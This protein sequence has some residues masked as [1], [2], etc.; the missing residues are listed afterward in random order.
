M[1]DRSGWTVVGWF[2]S[3]MYMYRCSLGLGGQKSEAQQTRYK[4]IT[5]A[6]GQ[7]PVKILAIPIQVDGNQHFMASLSYKEERT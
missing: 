5:V 7:S 1:A 6:A 4:Y 3:L 2:V